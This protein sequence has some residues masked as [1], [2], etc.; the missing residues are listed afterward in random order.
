MT[1]QYKNHTFISINTYKGNLALN[2]YDFEESFRFETKI[3]YLNLLNEFLIIMD[4][5]KETLKRKIET[6]ND[7][8]N[9]WSDRILL[10]DS[11]K[12]IIIDLEKH[13]KLLKVKDNIFLIT[14]EKTTFFPFEMLSLFN[15]KSISRIPS[16][17]H[18]ELF[19]NKTV[20]DV[21]KVY[22][23]LDPDNNLPNTRKSINDFL[24]NLCREKEIEITNDDINAQT[25]DFICFE[26]KKHKKTI[27]IKGVIGRDFTD[28][29]YNEVLKSDVFFYFGHGNADKYL[30]KNSIKNKLVFLF[31]CSSSKTTMH[32]NFTRNGVVMNYLQNLNSFIGCLWDITDKDLD[33]FCIYFLD[34][35]FKNEKTDLSK[36]IHDLRDNMKLKYLNGSAIVLWGPSYFIT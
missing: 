21:K 9:W 22:F 5:S 17:E 14:D 31:G 24:K 16:F 30:K 34:N 35:F 13:F 12:K 36:L 7:N 4:K 23:L 28:S 18:L 29:D 6:S 15:K 32:K 20:I 3:N 26:Y 33:R 8:H 27:L 1:K 19:K 2:I 25:N 10:D 11:L